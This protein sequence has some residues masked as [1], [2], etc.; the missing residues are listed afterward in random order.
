M[1]FDVLVD[2]WF[3]Q[4][5]G[6]AARVG[7]SH[8]QRFIRTQIPHWRVKYMP[9]S[10]RNKPIAKKMSLLGRYVLFKL[11]FFGG[12][13]E[14]LARNFEMTRERKSRKAARRRRPTATPIPRRKQQ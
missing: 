1:D 4:T 6:V 14:V 11:R 8:V 12:T 2:N 10:P 13:V 3:A 5:D 7:V 9:P